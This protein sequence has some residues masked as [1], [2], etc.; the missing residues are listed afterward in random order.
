MLKAVAVK[1]DGN[2]AKM[3][4]ALGI[5]QQSAYKQLQ[6]PSVKKAVLSAREKALKKAGLTLNKAYQKIADGMKAGVVVT[7]GKT[8]TE[9]KAPDYKERREHTKIALQAMGELQGNEGSGIIVNMPIILING[10]KH[11]FDVGEV[12]DV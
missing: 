11:D 10:K 1:A 3:G 8:A 9:T 12:I 5:A 4:K 6:K 7:N 2:S